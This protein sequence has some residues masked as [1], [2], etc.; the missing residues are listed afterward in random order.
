MG[1]APYNPLETENLMEYFS[2]NWVQHKQKINQSFLQ[3]VF[4]SAADIVSG[5]YQIPSHLASGVRRLSSSTFFKSNR[6]PQFSSNIS[7]IWHE[8][9]QQC[10][11]I[12]LL[13]FC[14]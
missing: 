3:C 9:A 12:I 8:C 2:A 11:G 1:H 6:L 7:N 4:S 13:N 5:A 10:C 14:F